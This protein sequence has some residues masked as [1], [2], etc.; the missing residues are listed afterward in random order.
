MILHP[1][2]RRLRRFKDGELEGSAR[3]R[4]ADHLAGCARCQDWLRSIEEIRGRVRDATDIE[5]PPDLWGRIRESRNR[6]EK[7]ILP[8]SGSTKSRTPRIS[9]T[10]RA[11]ILLLSL[12]GAGAAAVVAAPPGS[13]LRPVREFFAPPVA[14]E[15]ERTTGIRVPITGDVVTVAVEDPAD[16]LQVG[17]RRRAGSELGVRAFGGAANA[18]FRPSSDGVRI[19]RAGAGRLEIDLPGTVNR[20]LVTV[21]GDSRWVMQDG[22]ARRIAPGGDAP[23]VE[24]HTMDGGS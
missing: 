2:F 4:L 15:P 6:G 18:V 19:T 10:S 12:V 21:D 23:D 20:A 9:R 14:H 8:S 5:P 13:W 17:L 24:I 1:G 22:R 11:A 16:G 3:R 7:V